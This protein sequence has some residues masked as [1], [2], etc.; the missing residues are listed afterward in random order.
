[1]PSCYFITFVA[2][3][4]VA[5]PDRLMLPFLL[6]VL[7]LVAPAATTA[8]ADPCRELRIEAFARKP[9]EKVSSPEQFQWFLDKTR[10]AKACY[11]ERGSRAVYVDEVWALYHLERSEE[12]MDV[13]RTFFE[14]FDATEEGAMFGFMY[15]WRGRLRHESYHY[16]DALSDYLRALDYQTDWPPERR[17]GLRNDIGLTLQNLRDFDE[18]HTSST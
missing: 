9:V 14:R 4:S 12:A 15:W 2:T 11:G 5:C 1:M 10:A 6:G 18:A 16:A 3:P 7:L 17:P 13:I 8:Y